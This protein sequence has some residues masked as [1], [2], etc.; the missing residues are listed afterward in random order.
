MT[1]TPAQVLGAYLPVVRAGHGLVVVSDA[2]GHGLLRQKH[3]R[4]GR[5]LTGELLPRRGDAAPT[6]SAD[7]SRLPTVGAP[8]GLRPRTHAI[9]AY[10]ENAIVAGQFRPRI[11]VRI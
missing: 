3:P 1:A 9:T 4:A 6:N 2:A 5:I 8:L 10:R 11:D 7:A